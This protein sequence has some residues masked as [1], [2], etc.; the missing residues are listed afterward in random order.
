[1]FAIWHKEPKYPS[2]LTDDQWGLIG[3]LIPP[4]P[5]RGN[6]RRTAVAQEVLKSTGQ[7]LTP[8]SVLDCGRGMAFQRPSCRA[9][10]M[11]AKTVGDAARF[12]ATSRMTGLP[13]NPVARSA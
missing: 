10:L 11:A 12:F 13:D 3:P 6:D 1:M 2:D 7:Q 8:A 5:P 9:I 4:S